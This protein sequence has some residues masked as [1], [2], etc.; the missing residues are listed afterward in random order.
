MYVLSI[1]ILYFIF[2]ILEHS[3]II[4]QGQENRCRLLRFAGHRY[5]RVFADKI[6]LFRTACFLLFGYTVRLLAFLTGV[7]NGQT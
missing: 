7:V 3:A 2:Q 6:N 4:F 5:Q 1:L